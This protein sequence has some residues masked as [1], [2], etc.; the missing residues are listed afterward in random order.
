MNMFSSLKNT[1]SIL[2]I[3]VVFV[4]FL[5]INS[6]YALNYPDFD[7]NTNPI[8]DD[9]TNS[10]LITGQVCYN[11][12]VTLLLNSEV[13]EQ[14]RIQSPVKIINWREEGS[15]ITLFP[16]QR[17]V[18]NYSRDELIDDISSYRV[19]V[20]EQDDFKSYQ[21][22]HLSTEFRM[23]SIDFDLSR[24]ILEYNDVQESK[25]V[26]IENPLVDFNFSSISRE[27]LISGE[28]TIAVII[29]KPDDFEG[30]DEEPLEQAFV[31]EFSK[32]SIQFIMDE[33][34][35]N[36]VNLEGGF[37]AGRVTGV[38]DYE[39][40]G[41]SYLVNGPGEIITNTGLMRS[42]EV[43]ETTGEFNFTL[44]ANE[45][46]EGMNTLD[47]IA[48]R[49]EN[50]GT[51]VGFY[52][53]EILRATVPPTLTINSIKLYDGGTVVNEFREH[54]IG[55]EIFTGYQT[56]ELNISVDAETLVW[57]YDSNP[58]DEV[59]INENVVI[60]FN[61]KRGDNLVRDISN[62][63]VREKSI[64]QIAQEL[65]VSREVVEIVSQAYEKLVEERIPR[66]SLWF[67][68]VA[69]QFGIGYDLIL[70][71]QDVAGNKISTSYRI[72]FNDE[73]PEL[74]L[75]EMRPNSVFKDGESFNGI[76]RIQGRTNQPNVEISIIAIGPDDF[77][78]VDSGNRVRITCQ[79]AY[80]YYR[81]GIWRNY[82][83]TST[84]DEHLTSGTVGGSF[85]LQFSDLL[86][87]IRGSLEFKSDSE[88]RFGTSNIIEAIVGG[89]Y[90]T[91]RQGNDPNQRTAQ[92]RNTLC[93]LMKNSFGRTNMQEFNVNYLTGNTDWNVDG[94]SF[95][96]NSINPYEIESSVS[97]TGGG[98][99]TSVVIEMTY[100]GQFG[101]TGELDFNQ[102][103][104]RKRGTEP[105]NV[106]VVSSEVVY[107][108]QG[109][110]LNLYV[111]LEFTRRDIPVQDYPNTERLVLE[112]IPR[113]VVQGYEIDN[114]NPEFV[115]IEILY[116]TN[117]L[118]KWLTPKMI[119]SGI[120]FLNSTLELTG[121]LRDTTR[122][123]V[124]VG[125]LSCTG[126]RFWYTLQSAQ[127]DP[128]NN[129]E[130]EERL[131]QLK[132]Q[133]YYVC[134][135][136]FCSGTPNECNPDDIEQSQSLM[137]P[138]RDEDGNVR[139]DGR[140]QLVGVD[141][142]DD[143]G[144]FDTYSNAEHGQILQRFNNL[145]VLGEC[146]VPG[147]NGMRGRIVTGSVTRF[148][149][150]GSL[151]YSAIEAESNLML[152]RRCVPYTYS[153]ALDTELERCRGLD[154]A[155]ER[156]ECRNTAYSNP[157][158]ILGV[159]TQTISNACYSEEAPRMD[160]TRCFGQQG[161]DP[162]DTIIDSVMCG[163]IPETY[164]HLNKLYRIQENIIDCLEDVKSATV[165]GTYCE[166]L[167][168]V[169]L[170]DAVTGVVFR[171]MGDRQVSSPEQ[172]E[173][174]TPEN[175]GALAALF[176][177]MQQT[178]QVMDDRYAGQSFY[179]SR[180]GFNNRMIVN[181]LCLFAINRDFSMF[182]QSMIG[183]LDTSVQVSPE[184]ARTIPQTRFEA[185]NPITSDMTISYRFT[186]NGV[187]GG[188]P[189][190]FTYELICDSG[191][192]NGEYCP[193]G[194]TRGVDIDPSLYREMQ[195]TISGGGQAQELIEIRDT[196]AKFVFNVL[197]TTVEY[198]I[199]DEQKRRVHEEVIRR[200]PADILGSGAF[201]ECSF[202][203]GVAGVAGIGITCGSQFGA[204]SDI[205]Y[206]EI[207]QNSRVAPA[208]VG[209]SVVF[210]PGDMVGVNIRYSARG[211]MA[212]AH[213]GRL[214]Y[215]S[216]CGDVFGSVQLD[217]SL[218]TSQNGNFYTELFSIPELGSTPQPTGAQEEREGEQ[219]TPAA[220]QLR[221]GSC[222][223]ELRMTGSDITLSPDN[224]QLDILE[225][226]G[227][228]VDPGTARRVN[229][230]FTTN[231]EIRSQ[232][233]GS[234]VFDFI[235]PSEDS[236]ICV[237]QLGQPTNPSIIQIVSFSDISNINLNLELTQFRQNP[238]V[239]NMQN[240]GNYRNLYQSTSING[241]FTGVDFT[242]PKGARLVIRDGE[243]ISA[244]RSVNLRIC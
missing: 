9:E 117:L 38:S 196:K 198:S 228:Q 156:I 197:R 41:F 25:T 16:N 202:N 36:A 149:E 107:F 238:M 147:G 103:Q 242:T 163:C 173:Y 220:P 65:E 28:N 21:V 227:I 88:G 23:S 75:D 78:Q 79:N 44:R 162:S 73:N 74:V 201:A 200:G 222:R 129:P 118:T 112:I 192:E 18:I 69:N 91:F 77:V 89:D 212:D 199:G 133:L 139:V 210:T 90:I 14:Q 188:S 146:E 87:F 189:V 6:S 119:D 49:S 98:Y 34:N 114:R 109:G 105:R 150:S 175:Q 204:M 127:L 158:F 235:S 145:Q 207:L 106:R 195:R 8:F 193:E 96:K 12:E 54:E 46:R 182:E 121:T 157:S 111:P 181:N 52:R 214:W 120:S 3:I 216:S 50:K 92:H 142:P 45:F 55:R 30:G 141:V 122:K 26:S 83:D 160:Q 138:Q 166:R 32:Y 19:D 116:D 7:V 11:C 20:F 229:Q 208:P 60:R 169:S 137:S 51:F 217:Q 70:K 5:A 159:D 206:F 17:F 148:E 244:T 168:S 225:E 184:Y 151:F 13:V 164:Q 131:N 218:V 61:A 231:Y 174:D 185:Y 186:H 165:E 48:H 136:T 191:Q 43:N 219:Q 203:A 130:H 167:I 15:T 226:Q 102:V 85:S 1:V 108:Y 124:P 37:L 4:I 171:F 170:C 134:D 178:Q 27:D 183:N 76:E 140:G 224:F 62:E 56:I 100:Q 221:E 66:N 2:T 243:S 113:A 40:V 236:T 24:I 143:L 67:R 94:V 213:R 240:T 10:L 35:R 47:L 84:L 64:D 59:V 194:Y 39:E 230:V 128:Q 237:N 211:S 80:E 101:E 72:I 58:R 82:E 53:V 110:R 153:P 152:Q 71:A 29:R 123:L 209:G 22:N 215:K 161:M 93:V 190:R 97:R 154:D 205:S 179:D 99:R 68:E 187:S 63:L 33:S 135:R 223:L 176:G 234:T 57:E 144:V 42:F 126:A 95:N 241:Q 104:V 132:E 177:G 31:Y 125:V 232:R 180:G 233:E 86:E 172:R 155:Q 115:E 81:R 239:V